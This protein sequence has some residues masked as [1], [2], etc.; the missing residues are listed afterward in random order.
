MAKKPASKDWHR[1][2]IK[3]AVHKRGLTFTELS[4]RAG[5][6]S[7][8][9]C[10]QALHRSYPKAERIIAAAIGVPPEDIWPTRY[11]ARADAEA[12][13]NGSKAASNRRVNVAEVA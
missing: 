4:R 9:T 12:R 8:D 6:L 2:D 11:A 3:A 7:A 10:S 1:A 5:Y 13:V